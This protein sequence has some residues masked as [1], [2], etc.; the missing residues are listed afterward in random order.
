M[1]LNPMA[2][3]GGERAGITA[4]GRRTIAIEDR[5]TNPNLLLSE[6]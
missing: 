2:T 3:L 1:L 6:R 5:N 4:V